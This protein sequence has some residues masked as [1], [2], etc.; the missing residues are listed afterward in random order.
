MVVSARASK[1]DGRQVMAA[2][3]QNALILSLQPTRGIRVGVNRF[4]EG[5]ST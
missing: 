5:T 4:Q 2:Q 3:E 1:K